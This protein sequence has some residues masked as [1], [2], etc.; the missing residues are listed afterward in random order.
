MIEIK[1]SINLN[2][3]GGLDYSLNY[4][5]C[6]TMKQPSRFILCIGS[7]NKFKEVISLRRFATPLAHFLAISSL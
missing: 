2:E 3:G 4:M 7:Y 5:E 6:I 1:I